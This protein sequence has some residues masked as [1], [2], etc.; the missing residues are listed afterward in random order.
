MIGVGW[1]SDK[2]CLVLD[3]NNIIHNTVVQ[4]QLKQ[5]SS[6]AANLLVDKDEQIQKTWILG[7]VDEQQDSTIVIFYGIVP[8]E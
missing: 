2:E 7:H 5:K 3:G 4:Q 1:I 6:L 8:K